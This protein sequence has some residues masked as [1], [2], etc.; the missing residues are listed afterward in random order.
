MSEPEIGRV[1]KN[2]LSPGYEVESEYDDDGEY[3]PWSGGFIVGTGDIV[4]ELT[5]EF[6]RKALL[7][8]GLEDGPDVSITVTENHEDGGYCPTC[9]FDMETFFIHVNGEEVYN[10]RSSGN[11]DESVFET[12]QNWL[13]AA[14]QSFKVLKENDDI[15]KGNE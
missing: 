5:G 15:P 8:V 7:R 11:Y 14:R 10:S 9:S 13:D 6:R 3:I 4:T 12:L 2:D 1:V